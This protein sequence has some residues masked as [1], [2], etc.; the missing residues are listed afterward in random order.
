MNTNSREIPYEKII[1]N[2]GG[3][4]GLGDNTEGNSGLL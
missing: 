1:Q 2:N 3:N 4:T